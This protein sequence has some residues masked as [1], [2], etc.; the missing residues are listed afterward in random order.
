ML[1]DFGSYQE[2]TG[3]PS[4]NSLINRPMQS[5]QQE[6]VN[7]D[8]FKEWFVNDPTILNEP[9]YQSQNYNQH[10]T[11]NELHFRK[12]SQ[13]HDAS[14]QSSYGKVPVFSKTLSA[15]SRGSVTSD[16]GTS[17]CSDADQFDPAEF[18]SKE[19]SPVS[20]SSWFCSKFDD[21]SEEYLNTLVAI[22]SPR[23]VRMS[24]KIPAKEARRLKR[25]AKWQP[26]TFSRMGVET[27]KADNEQPIH[28]HARNPTRRVDYQEEPAVVGSRMHLVEEQNIVPAESTTTFSKMTVREYLGTETDIC[29]VRKSMPKGR[30][31]QLAKR[32]YIESNRSH[33]SSSVQQ[34]TS[35]R[36]NPEET[37]SSSVQNHIDEVIDFIIDSV[38]KSGS[39]DSLLPPIESYNSSSITKLSVKKKVTKRTAVAKR[40]QP[41]T[42][43]DPIS[44]P[45]G[46]SVS[47]TQQGE[48]HQSEMIVMNSLKSIMHQLPVGQVLHLTHPETQESVG[49]VFIKPKTPQKPK[50]RTPKKYRNPLLMG[51]LQGAGNPEFKAA[52][53]QAKNCPEGTT[54]VQALLNNIKSETERK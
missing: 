6:K 19:P 28:I 2:A 22:P 32:K 39:A 25:I 11:L 44:L 13:F 18:F 51:I 9:N 43:F 30:L 48:A 5:S 38:K 14:F 34:S 36:S 16:T 4:N 42:Q 52:V 33:K 7:D 12:T 31:N 26:E 1:S 10:T 3:N 35:I 8:C 50:Q 24:V 23:R 49:R 27:I 21:V 54:D 47:T 37:V 53:K 17:S 45:I 29:N 46:T 41:P 15:L 20:S 40:P